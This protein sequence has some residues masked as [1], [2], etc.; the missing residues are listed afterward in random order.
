MRTI[1]GLTPKQSDLVIIGG[2]VIGTVT[3]YWLAKAGYKVVVVERKDI[4]SGTT[5][6]AAAAALL[7]T[8]TTPTKLALANESLHLLDQLHR[9]LE[10]SFEYE[11]SGSLLAATSDEEMTLICE[12]NEKLRSLGLEVELLDGAQARQYMP[13]LGD[14][15]V[16]GSYS[17]KD[18]QINP[19]ELVVACERAAKNLGVIFSTYNEVIGIE[20]CGDRI[21]A[22]QTKR[23]RIL[24]DTVI[25]A[26]GVWAT[27]IAEMAGL[28]LVISPLKGELLVT[29]RMPLS[30]KGT[31]IAASYLLS[32][33]GAEAKSNQRTVERT[34]G[35]TLVQLRHGNFIVGSTREQSGFDQR[36]SREGI[37]ELSYQL[38][39]LVP[40]LSNVHLLRAYAGLRPLSEDG[41]PIIGRDNKLPGFIFAVGFGGDGLAMSAL[42]AQTILD[43]L[44]DSVN[45]YLLDLF[46]PS[47]F[48]T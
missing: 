47:R 25:N 39:K 19:L 8:K 21:D 4:G 46:N 23:G 17:P 11:H 6:A 29:E 34:I 13:I 14:C 15:I 30:M 3:A 32:K 22:I 26:A 48:S 9:E 28:S 18:A 41:F 7:Q 40:S 31:L 24:T 37:N 45:P 1:D 2:G 42:A 10:F 5:S 43:V 33:T 16:G 27:R 35:I 38:L 44:T 20:V 12:M 36:N